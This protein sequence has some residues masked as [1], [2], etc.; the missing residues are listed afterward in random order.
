MSDVNSLQV[1]FFELKLKLL[2][3]KLS[4]KTL[5]F[6]IEV[7]ED[8]DVSVKF[9]FLFALDNLLNLTGFSYLF[10]ELKKILLLFTVHFNFDFLL[11]CS[12]LLCFLLN[13]L[14]HSKFHFI[15]VLLLDFPCLIN[16]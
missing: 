9:S 16:S 1:F 6:L 11:E 15:Q 14:M 10:F 12:K 2:V 13:M 3:A 7:Q 5:L 4:T 8:L